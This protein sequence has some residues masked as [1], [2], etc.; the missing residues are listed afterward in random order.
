[1]SRRRAAATMPASEE[2]SIRWDELEER[3][4]ELGLFP[5]ADERAQR[6]AAALADAIERSGFEY[7]AAGLELGLAR[8]EDVRDGESPAQ[9]MKR[10][11][12]ERDELRSLIAAAASRNGGPQ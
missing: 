10:Y 11:R 5:F 7:N 9:T 1:M 8:A 12:D 6:L 3:L 4:S 2:V